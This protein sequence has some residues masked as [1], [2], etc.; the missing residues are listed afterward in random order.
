MKKM[1]ITNNQAMIRSL[2]FQAPHPLGREERLEI[3]MMIHRAYT[4][5]L[6][7]KSPKIWGLGSFQVGEHI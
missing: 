4:M 5:K 6:P 7:E 2:E 1:L 3:A